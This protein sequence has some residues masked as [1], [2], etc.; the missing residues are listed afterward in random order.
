MFLKSA[1]DIALIGAA[2]SASPPPAPLLGADD[3]AEADDVAGRPFAVGGALRTDRGKRAIWVLALPR[4]KNK[5]E[6]NLIVAI[7]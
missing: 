1:L 3:V 7:I 5:I 6:E 4:L 2:G